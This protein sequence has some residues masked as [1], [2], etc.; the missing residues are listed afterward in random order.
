MLT[1]LNG[2]TNDFPFNEV[3]TLFQTKIRL[4]SK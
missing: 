2:L 1:V 3:T 4:I